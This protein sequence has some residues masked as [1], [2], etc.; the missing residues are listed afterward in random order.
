MNS[1]QDLLQAA[2]KLTHQSINELEKYHQD[3]LNNRDLSTHLDK[4]F[5]N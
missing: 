1:N 4:Q 3:I 5:S 2:N